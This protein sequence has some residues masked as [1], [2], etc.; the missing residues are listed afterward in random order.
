MST[1]NIQGTVVSKSSQRGISL[2]KVQVFQRGL[3]TPIA[4]TPTQV[5]GGFDVSFSWSDGRPDVHFRVTQT[6]NGTDEVIYNE[7]PATQTRQNIADVL[8]VT[9]ETDAGLSLVP[10]ATG[11]PDDSLFLFTRV[12]IIGVNQIDTVGAAASGYAFPDVDPAAPNSIGAN[13]PFGSTLDI[14]GW[15]GQF[16]GVFRYKVQYD[17]GTGWQD[18][19]DPL[20]NSYYDESVLGDGS[21]MTVALG[22][23]T[24]GG[25]S[26]V[27][28][29][30]DVEKPGQRWIF[31]DLIARWD[32]TKVTDNLYTLRIQGF[33][34]A[35]DG[36]TLVP[37]AALIIEP[38]FGNLKLRVDNSPPAVSI[39]SIEHSPTGGD[40]F[41]PVCVCDIV[42]FG[43]GK[44]RFTFEASDAEGHL[45]G[46]S[47]AALF[48]HN[49]VVAPPP[50]QAADSY[51]GHI[52]ATRHWN[53]GTFVVDYDG[54]VYTADKMPTCAYEFRLDVSKRTTNGYGNIFTGLGDTVHITLKRP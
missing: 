6:V 5:D 41:N 28:K 34:V 22:P 9:L 11:R 45:A 51:P 32:T 31:P 29:L 20:A 21:W 30:P 4:E 18:V 46:Y 8:S 53:G 54:S 49:Q 36:T 50:A 26:N 33:G 7:N 27:Y 52:D 43:S 24:E 40:P 16:A 44:L 39:Q 37:S 3:A 35:A 25:Q 2:A 38:D 19:D 42:P 17:D 47:L 14:A 48:G 13:S 12:G 10:S 1:F 23:F 15:F